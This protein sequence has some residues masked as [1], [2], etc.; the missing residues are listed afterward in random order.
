MKRVRFVR[1][2]ARCVKYVRFVRN[3]ARCVKCVRFVRSDERCVKRARFVRSDEWWMKCLRCSKTQ[4]CNGWALMCIFTGENRHFCSFVDEDSSL[5]F[6]PCGFIDDV[7]S[8]PFTDAMTT[9]LPLKA[10]PLHGWA[11]TPTHA[12]SRSGNTPLLAINE[13]ST[14]PH[15]HILPHKHT[16]PGEAPRVAGVVESD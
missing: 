6:H 5:K 1:S 11:W 8:Q 16:T 2:D 10:Q 9:P 12:R 14:H 4:P 7:P 13:P 15:N 3:G